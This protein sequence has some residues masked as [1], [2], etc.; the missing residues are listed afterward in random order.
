MTVNWLSGV[1]VGV[2]GSDFIG[3]SSRISA[4]IM[5][6]CKS[7]VFLVLLVMVCICLCV[8]YCVSAVGGSDFIGQIRN[9]PT[10]DSLEAIPQYYTLN[11]YI[12][13]RLSICVYIYIYMYIYIYIY[14]L[15]HIHYTWSLYI[16]IYIYIYIY[17]TIPTKRDTQQHQTHNTSDI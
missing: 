4:R 5:R 8:A 13:Y 9:G 1:L 6:A 7:C 16:Y 17:N 2:A 15:K 14:T 10:T 3:Q 11:I 12:I